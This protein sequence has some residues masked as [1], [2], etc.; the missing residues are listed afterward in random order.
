MD[1]SKSS[2][3]SEISSDPL[4]LVIGYLVLDEFFSSLDSL[5]AEAS[6]E[7][8]VLGIALDVV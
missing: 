2:I 8:L 7:D 1:I 6:F 3:N 4:Y 5:S